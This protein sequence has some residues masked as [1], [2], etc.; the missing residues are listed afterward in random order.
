M[1]FR[2][3]TRPSAPAVDPLVRFT[4][5]FAAF[6]AGR[7][8]FGDRAPLRLAAV[9]LVTTPGPAAIVAERVRQLDEELKP[10]YGWTSSVDASMRLVLA[11][12]LVRAGESVAAFVAA[13]TRVQ[14]LMREAKVRRGGVHEVL[15]ALTLRRVIGVEPTIAHVERMRGIYERMKHHHWFLTGPED[16]TAC[17]M[18]VGR[19][20]TPAQIGDHVEAIY[21][22]LADAPKVSGGDALQTAANVLGLVALAPDEAADRFLAVATALRDAGV[23]VRTSEYDE[24]AVLAFLPRSAPVVA[25]RVATMRERIAQ[26]LAWYEGDDATSLAT[27]L[28]FVELLEAEDDARVAALS[29]AKMLLDMQTILAMRQATMIA[30]TTAT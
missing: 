6:D 8:M 9:T 5:L 28:A 11:A 26:D 29:D 2:D 20:G 23:K 1:P 18:L 7:G 4:E 21:R 16:L 27:N 12:A 24:V 19:E 22:R 30:V 17:A 25:A 3:D 10:H 14:A 13:S 15:A